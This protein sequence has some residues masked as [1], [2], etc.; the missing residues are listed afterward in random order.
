MKTDLER[1]MDKVELI[2]FHSCWEWTGARTIG[3]YGRFHLNY[4]SITA[5]KWLWQYYN[6]SY[7]A[8]MCLDHLC[9]NRLCVNP[10]H[11]ELVTP[12]EN[13]RR[14]DAGKITGQKNKNKTHCKNGHEFVES[15]I[16]P[17]NNGRGCKACHRD[18]ERIRR[19]NKLKGE[20]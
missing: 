15:N 8:G 6:G 7:P 10:A 11:L 13:T 5:H 3:Q 4:K 16:R 19:A 1:F 17:N 2:P 9:R 12:A 14:G 20:K 18:R